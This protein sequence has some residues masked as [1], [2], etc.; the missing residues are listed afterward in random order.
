MSMSLLDYFEV[1]RST[2]FP[3][4]RAMLSTR[5]PSAAIE[6][7]NPEVCAVLN[8]EPPESIRRS[9]KV[10]L[11]KERAEIGKMAVH[12]GAFATAK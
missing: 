3:N 5:T 11:P 1:H 9:R 6:S 8:R 4:A 10:Y 7:A 2:S 12:I